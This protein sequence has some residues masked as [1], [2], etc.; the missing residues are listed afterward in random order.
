M[1]GDLYRRGSSNNLT[2]QYLKF[3]YNNLK[4]TLTIFEVSAPNKFTADFNKPE[5]FGF[6]D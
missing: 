6:T 3:V 4:G 5:N 2:L 1:I